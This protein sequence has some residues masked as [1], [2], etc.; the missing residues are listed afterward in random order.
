[1]RVKEHPVL[2]PLKER[3]IIEIIYNGKKLKSFKGDSIASA[4]IANGILKFRE[5]SK[6]GEPRGY[7]FDGFLC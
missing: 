3:E 5:T 2:D 4:L 6:I 7:F 1:M